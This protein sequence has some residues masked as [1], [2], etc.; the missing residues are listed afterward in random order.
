MILSRCYYL[1][2][3]DLTGKKSIL[4]IKAWSKHLTKYYNLK[5][6]L[7]YHKIINFSCKV[8]S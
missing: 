7:Q 5:L 8:K 3:I 6:T 4:A 2:S 1:V